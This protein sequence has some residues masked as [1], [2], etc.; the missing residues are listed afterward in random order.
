MGTPKD[1]KLNIYHVS[2][3]VEVP[4]LKYMTALCSFLPN[5]PT[6]AE[7]PLTKCTNCTKKEMM[8]KKSLNNLLTMLPKTPAL[9]YNTELPTFVTQMPHTLDWELFLTQLY[10]NNVEHVAFPSR[11]QSAAERKYSTIEK[12]AAACVLTFEEAHEQ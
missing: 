4:T 9:V 2:T 6:V 7:P 11:T 10:S 1:Y 8:H 5:Y 3:I 12:E